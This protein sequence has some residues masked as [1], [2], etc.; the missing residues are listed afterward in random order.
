MQ[1]SAKKCGFTLIELL[2]VIAIIAILIALLLPAVQQAREAARRT[3]CKN[4]LKQLGLALHNYHD[5]FNFFP[6][7]HW[8]NTSE[9]GINSTKGSVFVSLLPYFE[10]ASLYSSL[11][12][13]FEYPTYLGGQL[14][15]GKVAGSID[16]PTLRCPSDE[17][18]PTGSASVYSTTSYAPSMGSQ[19]KSGAGCTTYAISPLPNPV[20]SGT[21][22]WSLRA[23]NISGMFGYYPAGIR[24]RDVIDGTSNVIGMG[25]VRTGCGGSAFYTGGWG[26]MDS[27]GFEFTTLV[28]INFETC[29]GEGAGVASGACNGANDRVSAYG[30]KSRHVG[31]AQFVLM[32]GSVRFISQNVDF[33]TYNRLGDRRDGAVVGEF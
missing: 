6:G 28:P 21:W 30:F 9:A 13:N 33:L 2:V 3:Q 7:N 4:H 10:Q 12:F 19:S 5:V 32:D 31:G 26:W 25:E 15:G 22:G 14:V 24:M 29:P 17:Y 1:R 23:E 18:R 8:I 16:L 20:S 27:F 11:N